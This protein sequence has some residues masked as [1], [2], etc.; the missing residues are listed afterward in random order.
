MFDGMTDEEDEGKSDGQRLA[1]QFY[2]LLGIEEK[3]DGLQPVEQRSWEQL[4]AWMWSGV[5][6]YSDTRYQVGYSHGFLNGFSEGK[7]EDK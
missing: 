2:W 5:R 6:S 1:E 3:W 4:A 7:R